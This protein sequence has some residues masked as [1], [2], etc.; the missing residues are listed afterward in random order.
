VTIT[1]TGAGSSNSFIVGGYDY[2]GVHVIYT[3]P[4]GT[5]G[6]TSTHGQIGG[7]SHGMTVTV[8]GSR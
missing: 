6:F 8:I 3:A 1:W 5:T 4:S 2:T 7:Q